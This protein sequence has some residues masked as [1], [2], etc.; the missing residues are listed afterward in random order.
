MGKIVL[1]AVVVLLLGFA[2]ALSFDVDGSAYTK[3]ET[4]AISGSSF[5][6]AEIGINAVYGAKIVFGQAVN[7]DANGNFSL[8]YEIPYLAPSGDWNIILSDG[9]Y[10]A[11]EIVNVGL[12]AA[13]A[14]YVITFLSPTTEEQKRASDINISVR[15][16][17]SG[18]PVGNARVFAWGIGGRA[19]ELFESREGVYSAGYEIPYDSGLGKSSIIATA[20][21]EA[22]G[23]RFG[24]ETAVNVNVTESAILIE[25]IEPSLKSFGLG[26]V[27][28]IVINASYIS[29]KPADNAVLTAKIGKN[30]IELRKKVDG[31]YYGEYE[32][33]SS[34]LGETGIRINA[35]DSA[36]N[37]G[38]KT[39][40]IIVSGWLMWFIRTNIIYISAA[41]I[42]I[43]MFFAA[44]YSGIKRRLK[45]SSARNERN[46]AVGMLE[47]AQRDYFE[48]RTISRDAYQ[49]T[50]S[51]CTSIIAELDQ[52]IKAL[53]KDGK[54]RDKKKAVKK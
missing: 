16:T 53:E 34:D 13:S 4:I 7:A 40:S 38:T 5:P 20:E 35:M 30:E 6:D 47:K 43:L 54:T 44:C 46:R 51:K 11:S 23:Q 19:I 21:K 52:K 41:A 3:G 42:I 26:S 15:V 18:M 50:S 25:I 14:R 27:I 9:S 45:L 49:R 12:D 31:R 8:L 33:S 28:P 1:A 37:R 29:G 48:K 39:T 22:D 32:T 36:G 24:G 2:G 17:D 10:T